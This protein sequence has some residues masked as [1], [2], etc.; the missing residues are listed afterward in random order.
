MYI[1]YYIEEKSVNLFQ[2]QPRFWDVIGSKTLIYFSLL[3]FISDINY[4]TPSRRYFFHE[5]I[6]DMA[7]NFGE[8]FIIFIIYRS[9]DVT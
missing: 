7:R 4:A 3:N 8:P 1:V 6:P 9:I 5:I 2:D